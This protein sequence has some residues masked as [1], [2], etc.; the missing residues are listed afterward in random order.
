MH[1]T[2]T[3]VSCV[4]S[5][6]RSPI[7]LPRSRQ[8][9]RSFEAGL[10]QRAPCQSTGL[11]SGS[12]LSGVMRAA[13]RRI[14]QLPRKVTF[15]TPSVASSTSLTSRSVFVSNQAFS[16]RRCIHGLAPSYLSRYCIPVRLDCRSVTP[17]FCRIY[18]FQ[19]RTL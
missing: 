19:R 7:M 12:I 16:R 10:L 4:R 15:L 17:P 18:S 5:V 13:A 1:C 2:F 14:L 3:Y 11:S 9:P 6:E 8:G